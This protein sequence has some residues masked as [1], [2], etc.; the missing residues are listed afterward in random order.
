MI[1]KSEPVSISEISEYIK[2]D[3]STNNE[4]KNFIKKFGKL[5]KEDAKKLKEEINDLNLIKVKPE[6]IT[7]IIDFLP[8]TKEDLNKI[9]ID[10]GLDED[11]TKK[12]LEKIK[13]FN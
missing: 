4:L 13:K 9:F 7:K 1:K 3:T 11:E 12:I 5:K 2:E 8:D 6:D 10:I